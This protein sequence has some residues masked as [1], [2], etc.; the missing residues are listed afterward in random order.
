MSDAPGTGVDRTIITPLLAMSVPDRIRY[1]V[2]ATKNANAFFGKA[3]TPPLPSPVLDA[4]LALRALVENRVE[5]IVVDGL[6]GAAWGS[7]VVSLETAICYRDSPANRAA[8]ERTLEA[9]GGTAGPVHHA[10][11][12]DYEDLLSRATPVV[13]D[14]DLRVLVCSL[15][16][17]IRMKRPL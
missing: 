13:I 15:D 7:P 11:A 14:P 5:F 9:L 4:F 8:L 1:I 17:L 16:D 12:P 2:A 10:S 3:W 6:A